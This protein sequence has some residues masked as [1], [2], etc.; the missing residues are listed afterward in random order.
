M[1]K[2]AELLVQGLDPATVV[3]KVD[4]ELEKARLAQEAAQLQM[5]RE[6]KLS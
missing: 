6:L 2:Y 3:Q 5:Q 1:A 4:P